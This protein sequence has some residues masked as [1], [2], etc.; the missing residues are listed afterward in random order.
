[1]KKRSILIF[2]ILITLVMVGCS[3]IKFSEKADILKV[4]SELP[5]EITSGLIQ[6]FEKN[7]KGKFKIELVKGP[8]KKDQNLANSLKALECD[9]WLGGTAEDYFL[10][11]N[12]KMLQPYQAKDLS[13]IPTGLRDKHG[14]WTG[15]FTTNLVFVA[16]RNSLISLGYD[17]PGSWEDLLQENFQHELVISDPALKQGGYRLLTTLW[18]LFGE[19]KFDEYMLR[20]KKQEP[21]YAAS[22][23]AA[24]E[25][26]RKGRKALTVVPLDLAMASAVKNNILVVSVPAEGTSRKVIG[27]AIIAGTKQ[28]ATS[29]AFIDYLVS[30]SAKAVLDSSE[31][32]VWSLTDNARDYTWGKQYSDIFLIHDDLRWCVLNSEEIIDKLKPAKKSNDL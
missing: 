6:G 2:I 11:D 12:K 28:E 8:L 21:E 7:S 23:E 22:D 13:N 17:K 19:K 32:Y 5:E 20:F 14:A 1:M 30:D 18:Q 16:N 24:I 15:L 25:D 29:R 10:A 26:V 27:A 3:S 31:Y 4:Y 9:I